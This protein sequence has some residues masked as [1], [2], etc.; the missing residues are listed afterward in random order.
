VWATEFSN[1]HTT[2]AYSEK[3]IVID[4]LS[5]PG[6]EQYFQLQKSVGTPD[7]EKAKLLMKNANPDQAYGIGRSCQMRPDWEDQKDMVMFKALTAKFT[8]QDDLKQLLLETGENLLVQL[9]P[10]DGYWGTGPDGRGKNKHAEILMMVRNT[11][12]S[13]VF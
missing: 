2:F 11:I 6:P 7:E 13:G 5:Y 4:G 3:P 8:Q 1:V 9:K 12:R 10:N